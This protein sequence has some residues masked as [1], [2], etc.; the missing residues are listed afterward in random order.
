MK[1]NKCGNAMRKKRSSSE[2]AENGEKACEKR[3]I[4]CGGGN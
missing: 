1:L 3:N 2:T 4:A